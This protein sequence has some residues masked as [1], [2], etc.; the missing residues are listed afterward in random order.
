[1]KT[2]LLLI[3]PMMASIA[4]A[5]DDCAADVSKYT[6]EGL[7]ARTSIFN[8]K[9]KMIAKVLPSELQQFG[10]IDK[11]ELKDGTK[12]TFSVG[13]CAHY[14]YFFQFQGEKISE[15]KKSGILQRAE[16]L[17][18]SLE[19]TKNDERKQ[20]LEAITIARKLKKPTELSEGLYQLPCGDANCLVE[21]QGK[22][23]VKISYDFAL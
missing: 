6:A 20:L 23:N 4:F 2:L 9:G 7:K 16:S 1:M 3:I 18:K 5:N 22:Q 11:A 21:D 13:G 10:F 15:Q 14:G 19:V 8:P 12:V 17:L